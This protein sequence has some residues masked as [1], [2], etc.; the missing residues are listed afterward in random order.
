MR[1]PLAGLSLIIG[2]CSPSAPHAAAQPKPPPSVTPAQI[3]FSKAIPV[4]ENYQESVQRMRP[5][6][7]LRRNADGGFPKVLG[8]SKPSDASGAIQERAWSTG[9]RDC[10][11]LKLG[12]DYDG[13]WVAAHTPGLTD[14]KK[15]T[16]KEFPGPDRKEWSD[17]FRHSC[18]CRHSKCRQCRCQYQERLFNQDRSSPGQRR[19]PSFSATSSQR[20]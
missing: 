11:Y 3:D 8:R 9:R 2:G 13:S 16:S 7:R 6:Q 15:D 4:D 14:L 18:L 10:L 20:K 1:H 5:T 12:V 17:G 19:R